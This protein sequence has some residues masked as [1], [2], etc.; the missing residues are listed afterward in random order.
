M[1][2]L[3]NDL[4][5]KYWDAECINKILEQYLSRCE[6]W[7]KSIKGYAKPDIVNFKC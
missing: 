3:W 6:T 2:S 7:I 5:V 4:K 1:L